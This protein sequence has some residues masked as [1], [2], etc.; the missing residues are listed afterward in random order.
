MDKVAF[1][2]EKLLNWQKFSLMLNDEL[3]QKKPITGEIQTYLDLQKRMFAVWQN[4]HMVFKCS[5]A[6]IQ[7][8]F[9]IWDNG[10]YEFNDEKYFEHA[11]NR[12]E[13][14]GLDFNDKCMELLTKNLNYIKMFINVLFFTK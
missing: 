1:C 11:K 10:S 5:M 13:D 7:K 14:V 6:L 2:K 12:F 4:N 8:E 9:G 3:L